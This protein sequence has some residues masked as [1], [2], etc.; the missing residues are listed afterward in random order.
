MPQRA[1]N[2]DVH[3]FF[4]SLGAGSIEEVRVTRDKGFGFVRYSTHEEAALAIQMGNGQLFGGR[5]IR[6]SWGKKP[7]PPGTAS[8]PLPPPTPAPF[9]SGVSATDFLAYQRLA[10]SKIAAN[11]ALVGQHGLKQAVL[12]MDAGASQ[13]IY[14]GGFQ[15]VN[16]AA[17]AAAAQQQHQQLMYF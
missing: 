11:S 4:H 8:S 9:P 17:A 15:G 1:T 16:P 7:T 14:D 2:N 3:L 5:L 12:G 13:A 6:C 10:L